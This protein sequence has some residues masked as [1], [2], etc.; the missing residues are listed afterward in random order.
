MLLVPFYTSTRDKKGERLIP[1]SIVTVNEEPNS[2]FV[3][4]KPNSTARLRLF[5]FPYAGGGASSF[6]TWT[7]ELTS[8]IEI[9]GIQMP[10]L[11]SRFKERPIKS[12]ELVVKML[13]YAIY[14][15][16]NKPFAFFGHSLGAFIGFELTR[17]LGKQFGLKP[18]HLFVSGIRAPHTPN[19]NPSIHRLPRGA[20]LKELNRRY[21][22]IIEEIFEDPDL[23]Q[24]LLPGL[25]ASFKM[26]ESYKYVNGDPLDCP[27]TAFGGLQDDTTSQ[28]DL[29]AWRKQTKSTFALHMMPGN[30]FFIH[31]ERENFLPTLSNE[32]SKTLAG[33]S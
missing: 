28:E 30:H 31:L 25:R 2:W 23:V 32:V 17:Q 21:G 26:Y 11:E 33:I 1:K 7:K 18:V 15:K 14:S 27:I 22:G 29:E 3:C 10:G 24:E 5:C 13:A 12:V 4:Y 19:S 9:I 20:F 16:L 6:Y 8:D